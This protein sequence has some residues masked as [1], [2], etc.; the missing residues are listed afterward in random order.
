MAGTTTVPAA[1]Q[2]QLQKDDNSSFD[3]VLAGEAAVAVGECS[4]CSL[5]S[6]KTELDIKQVGAV[7]ERH[8]LK[9][10]GRSCK[11]KGNSCK[12]K[13]TAARES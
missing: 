1:K 9:E 10:K 7:R 8:Q 12:T 11:I 4:M 6:H 2:L 3:P 13:V 5:T